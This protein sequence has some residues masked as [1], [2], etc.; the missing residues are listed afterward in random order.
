MSENYFYSSLSGQEIEDTLVGAVRF[1]AMQGLTTAQKAQARQNIGAGE[2]NTQIKIKGFYDTL[3]DL[4]QHITVG[5]EGDVYAVGT[6][7]PY[8][9]YIWDAV[10]IRWV[11]NG[12]ISFSDAIIDD[13]DVSTS[14]TWSSAKMT[15]ELA[16]QKAEIDSDIDA[17]TQSVEMVA[18]SLSTYVRP[19]LLDNWYFG[20]GFPVNQRG[21]YI[22]ASAG[23]SVDR[24]KIVG[25]TT[26]VTVS[27]SFLRI[28]KSTDAGGE[29]LVQFVDNQDSLVGKT[30][31]ISA[32]FYDGSF[33]QSTVNIPAEIPSGTQSI[34]PIGVQNGIGLYLRAISGKLAIS[35][36][37]ISTYAAETNLDIIAVKMELGP[38]Q[39]LAHEENGTWV[40]NEIPDYD[41]ELSKCQRYLRIVNYNSEN[42]T[43]VFGYGGSTTKVN[44][45]FPF[46]G[47]A[48]LPTISPNAGSHWSCKKYD[49]TTVTITSLEPWFASH[50]MLGVRVNGSGIT[51]N[52]SYILSS[53]SATPVIFSCEP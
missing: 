4:Q 27:A 25:S 15:N 21:Q 1:N 34:A 53:N 51:Q 32:L 24:W 18:V 40:L 43:S 8:D 31:T 44:V 49:G 10:N 7:S 30:V 50:S 35:F 12:P 26:S 45:F 2:E 11:N 33:L 48:G 42:Y 29:M 19:N 9:L 13:N 5:T 28:S 20:K 6:A 37:A 14:S 38:T 52:A 41:S 23:Y 47:M 22:Y 17:V 36:Y 46:P 39:T 3:E 16:A